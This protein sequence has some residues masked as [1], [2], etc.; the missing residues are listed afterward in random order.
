MMHGQKTVKRSD[1]LRALYCAL[2][3]F[4]NRCTKHVKHPHTRKHTQNC[5]TLLLYTVPSVWYI[6]SYIPLEMFSHITVH[7]WVIFTGTIK[8][9]PGSRIIQI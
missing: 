5:L 2:L 3:R 8:M 9:K 1:Y 7:R 4:K 6:C